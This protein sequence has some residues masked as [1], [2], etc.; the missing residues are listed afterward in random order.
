MLRSVSYRL[1]FICS[2]SKETEV[3]DTVNVYYFMEYRHLQ[4]T[5]SV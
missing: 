4:V 1:R 2:D 3:I 5:E